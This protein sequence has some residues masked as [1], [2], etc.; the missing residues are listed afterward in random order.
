ML[1]LILFGTILA[2]LAASYAL[3]ALVARARFPRASPIATQASLGVSVLKPLYG[4]EPRLAANLRSFCTQDY[5]ADWQIVFGVRDPNDPAVAVVRELQAEYPDRDLQLVIDGEL[6][7]S[8]YKVSN[9]INIF[10]QCRYEALVIA[11]SDIEV[12]FDYLSR[13]VAPLADRS[14]GIVTCLYRGNPVGGP[15]SQ[16][17]AQFIDEWFAPSVL[18]SNLFGS[19]NFAFGATIALHRDSLFEAGGLRSIADQLADDWWLGERVRRQGLTTVL[20]ECVVSTDVIED[21]LESL[22]HHELRWLRTIRGIQPLGYTLSVVTIGIP[23]ALTGALLAQASAPALAGLV[24]TLGA[25]YLLH[26]AP[27]RRDETAKKKEWWMPIVRDFLT[28]GLWCVSFAS[29]RVKWGDHGLDV[30]AHGAVRRIA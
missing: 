20:S 22:V 11:D 23:V 26:Y 9:L 12:P 27:G 15:W 14:V 13:V 18:V 21:S 5:P 3:I 10:G 16:L 25:R 7:G 29:R 17:G 8:N 2:W 24:V 30:D 4:A 6:H 1:L 19:R 28:L